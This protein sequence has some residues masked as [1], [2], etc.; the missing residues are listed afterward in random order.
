M[1]VVTLRR[2]AFPFDFDFAP[3][4]RASSSPSLRA[5]CFFR[6]ANA[7]RDDVT[8]DGIRRKNF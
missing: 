4:G 2:R 3:L 6:D 5:N 1:R 7:R 8:E